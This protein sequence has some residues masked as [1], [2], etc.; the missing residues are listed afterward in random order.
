[1]YGYRSRSIRKNCSAARIR[2]GSWRSS[3]REWNW[4]RHRRS[5]MYWQ[6]SLR[7]CIPMTTW[8][9][10]SPRFPLA[11]QVTSNVRVALETLLGAVGLVLLMACANVANLLLSRAAARQRRDRG[12]RRA[13]R[14]SRSAGPTTP[15]RERVSG[16]RSAASRG[17]FSH[18]RRS[19]RLSPHLPADLS[20]AAGVARGCA[21]A[22]VHRGAF[23]WSREF[24]SGWVRSFG[25]AARECGRIA[26]AEQSHRG[27]DSL[28]SAQRARRGTDRDRDRSC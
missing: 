26:E 5:W 13:R 27:W 15:D 20:R 21:H 11:E 10:G 3:G 1:M 4:R 22:G 19:Q 12:S 8:T 23:R 24:S 18:S 28:A 6:R 7:G 2:C 16:R 9:R 14:Q 25:T 17:C